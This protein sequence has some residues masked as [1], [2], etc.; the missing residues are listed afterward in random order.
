MFHLGTRFTN[1]LAA[2]LFTFRALYCVGLFFGSG[3]A[4]LCLSVTAHILQT[5]NLGQRNVCA[6]VV[7]AQ[8][9]LKVIAIV[10]AHPIREMHRMT[11]YLLST[12]TDSL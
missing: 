12:L 3:R 5:D 4:N 11:L 7:R 9:R 2:L 8:H 1:A 6:G 10:R